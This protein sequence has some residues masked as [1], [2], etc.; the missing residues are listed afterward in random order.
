MVRN[1][2]EIAEKRTK[3]MKEILQGLKVNYFKKKR[4]PIELFGIWKDKIF[5]DEN[6]FLINRF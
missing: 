5:F 4:N 1:M 6:E 2:Q 3:K